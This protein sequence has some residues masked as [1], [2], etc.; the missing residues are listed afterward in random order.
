[1]E[2]WKAGAANRTIV[3][4]KAGFDAFDW[5]GNGQILGLFEPSHMQYDL[6]RNPAAEP[7][8][9]EMTLAA[10]KRLSK[11]PERLSC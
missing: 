4:D 7:S 10:I 6:D 9:A 5:N 8:I 1:M 11:N 3:T 2:E